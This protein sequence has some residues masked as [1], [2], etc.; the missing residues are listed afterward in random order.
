MRLIAVA[1]STLLL[2]GAAP[3]LAQ[4]P[5]QSPQSQR[6]QPTRVSAVQ[7]QRVVLICET[8]AAT[9]SAFTRQYGSEPVFLTAREAAEAKTAGQTWT[10]PR[11]MTEHQYNRL[12]A[13]TQT[14]ASL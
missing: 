5:E 14:R 3:A 7:P 12:V 9:R 10:T 2:A 4:S 6:P 1:V 8:D 11:C 13:F